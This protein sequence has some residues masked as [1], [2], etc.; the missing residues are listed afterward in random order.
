MANELK[1]PHVVVS[2]V[3]MVI[4]TL[5]IVGY[6]YFQAYGYWY[7]WGSILMLSIL[8]ILFMKKYFYLHIFH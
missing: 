7:L 1:V 3:Y 4:Q 6:F 8:Y 5:V 2:F